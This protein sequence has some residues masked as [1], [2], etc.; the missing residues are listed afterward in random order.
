MRVLMSLAGVL[1]A[2]LVVSKLA[3]LQ[4]RAPAGHAAAGAVGGEG[5]PAPGTAASAGATRVIQAMEQGAAQRAD[6]AASR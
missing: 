2:L 1:I 6:D 3:G 5:A 4:L